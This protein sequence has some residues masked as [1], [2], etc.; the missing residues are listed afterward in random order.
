M[1]VTHGGEDRKAL[2]ANLGYSH[3]R[4]RNLCFV[5]F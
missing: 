2:L 3:L 4:V 5:N 1:V